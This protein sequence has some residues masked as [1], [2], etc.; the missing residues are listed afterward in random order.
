LKCNQTI[1]R[2]TTSGH[3]SIFLLLLRVATLLTVLQCR[4]APIL[5]HFVA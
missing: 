2:Q 4:T 1:G 3:R 5:F